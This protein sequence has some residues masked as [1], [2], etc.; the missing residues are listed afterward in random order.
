[1]TKRELRMLVVRRTSQTGGV[2]NDTPRTDPTSIREND[3]YLERGPVY[4]LKT[5]KTDTNPLVERVDGP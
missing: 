3:P 2:Y 5:E 1:M 4:T